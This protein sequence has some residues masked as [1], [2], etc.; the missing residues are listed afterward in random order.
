MSTLGFSLSR[1]SRV[2]TVRGRIVGVLGLLVLADVLIWAATFAVFHH[3]PSVLE[4]IA[5]A[6]FTLGLAH[7]LDA[8]HIS[9]IDNVTRKLMQEGQ[10]PVGVG[11]FF[12]LGHST[13]VILLTFAV[14]ITAAGVKAH[15]QRL[16]DIGNTLGTVISS[17]FLLIVAGINLLVLRGVFNT[18]R[19]VRR[20][21]QYEEPDM[22]SI[23]IG[24]GW[25]GRVVRPLFR[26]V[27]RSWKMYGVGFLFGLGFDTATQVGLLAVA[28][29]AAAQGMSIWSVMLFPALFTGGMC[30]VDTL[31][32]ILML[33][34]YGW[35][36]V[37]PVRKLYYNMTITAVSVIIA[38]VIGGIEL[39]GVIGDK[40]DLHGRL[41]DIVAYLS[42][43]NHFK[44]VGAVIIGI[45]VLSWIASTLNYRLMGFH[46]LEV[47]VATDE[48][49]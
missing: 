42:D 28:A 6:A 31:D 17:V 37:H 36:Y 30:L 32:G 1:S 9:A 15:F 11:F 18:F 3:F 27:D 40:Y 13:I 44:L 20:G 38:V 14:A 4:G 22:E 33:G 5:A 7:A 16:T 34:A 26:M 8:D 21:E 25:I 45:F 10:R 41:W 49:V 39:L 24:L 43:D 46:Q 47:P 35:A 23:L 19:K 48:K 2:S 29:T 12:S